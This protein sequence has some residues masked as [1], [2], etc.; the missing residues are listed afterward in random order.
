MQF[1][2]NCVVYNYNGVKIYYEF[3]EGGDIVNV[4]LHGWGRESS[5]FN[6]LRH[7]G[8][9]LLIDLP[10]FGK[11]ENIRN[12]S[13]FTYANMVICLCRHLNIRKY[14][15]IGHSFGGRISIIISAMEKDKVNKLVLIDSAGMKPK[16]N[17]NYKL[18]LIKIK[19]RKKLGL[20]I[21]KYAS[22]DYKNLSPEMKK[23]FSSIVNTHL[24]ESARLI[25]C[26]TLI[27]FGEKDKETPVYMA[28]KLNKLIKNSSL[29][30]LKNCAHFCFLER[31]IL[32]E[33]ILTNFIKEA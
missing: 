32:F 29:V 27:V 26:K 8:G 2:N 12:W 19:M 15:L 9:Y 20:S 18:K 31:K 28:K 16:R 7:L 3:I 24:E 6:E 11:S 5:D 25:D 4:F 21:D 30:I 22:S 17:L 1:I 13:I 14:N 23:V 33:E 10:P